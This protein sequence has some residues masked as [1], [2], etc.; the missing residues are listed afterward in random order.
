MSVLA[1]AQY[2]RDKSTIYNI[3]HYYRGDSPFS[4]R[5]GPSDVRVRL[6]K[7]RNQGSTAP[8]AYLELSSGARIVHPV[9]ISVM[10]A[11]SMK[12]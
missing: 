2:R 11:P 4:H 9:Y 7:I 10:T 1:I 5:S 12:P 8:G 6:A 3:M